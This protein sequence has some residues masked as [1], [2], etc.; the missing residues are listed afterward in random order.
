MADKIF[1]TTTNNGVYHAIEFAPWGNF[2]IFRTM[3]E[4]KPAD[5]RR[6][7]PVNRIK[8]I[9]LPDSVIQQKQQQQKSNIVTFGKR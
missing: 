3:E 8:E 4:G 1:I 9:E 6:L 7:I 2:V 5:F